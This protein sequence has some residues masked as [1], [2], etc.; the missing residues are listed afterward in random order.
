MM[1]ACQDNDNRSQGASGKVIVEAYQVSP[2]YFSATI[3]ATGDLLPY[4]EVDIKTPVSG[5]VSRIHFLEGQFVNKG[6]LLLEMDNRSWIAQKSGLEARLISTESEYERKKK[7][8]EIDGV[9]HEEVEQTLA[10][11][12]NLKARIEEL[13]VMIDL[14]QIRAPFSGKLGMRNFSPGAF[15]SQGET[16]TQLV[17]TD[18][19]KVNFSIPAKYATLPRNKQEVRIISSST[20]D[21]ALAVIYAIDPRINPATR[22]LRIR[23]LVSSQHPAFKPGDFVQVVLVVDQNEQALL[24]PAESIIPE[25]NTQMVY[26]VKNGVASRRAVEI[27]SR[28]PDRVQIVKGL[29]I[30]DTVLTTGLMEVRDGDPIEIRN[31]RTVGAE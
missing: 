29:A 19:L 8:L 10:E 6:A 11:R 27:T 23:A 18:R 17:Q 3:Q 20:G 1:A 13:D 31:V 30:G 7:L 24:I 22:N 14:A 28:T 16:L 5:L 26:V 9:S 4:E 15:L 21:T 12:N 25:L 2:E